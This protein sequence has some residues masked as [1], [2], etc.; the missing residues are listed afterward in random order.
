MSETD[1]P[2]RRSA[3][4]G[5]VLTALAAVFVAASVAAVAVPWLRGSTTTVSPRVPMGSATPQP[6]AVGPARQVFAV[7]CVRTADDYCPRY[8]DDLV[9]RR[10]LDPAQQVRVQAAA[11]RVRLVLPAGLVGR[12]VCEPTS[13]GACLLSRSAPT[14]NAVR[15]ALVAAGFSAVV[16]QARSGDPAPIGSVLFAVTAAPGCVVGFHDGPSPQS[17]AVGLLPDGHCL[18]G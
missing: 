10:Q 1:H 5:R 12:P 4:A 13:G 3:G 18:A 11:D 8:I 2:G 15:D 9:R 14:V 16:R 7:A 17:N 6:S